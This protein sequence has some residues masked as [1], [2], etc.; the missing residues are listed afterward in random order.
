MIAT[1]ESGHIFSR[2]YRDLVP[3]WIDG[4]IDHADGLRGRS[5]EGGGG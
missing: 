4:N 5:Q 2:H 1:G 3:L